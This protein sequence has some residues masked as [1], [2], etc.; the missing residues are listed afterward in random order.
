[1]KTYIINLPQSAERRAAME[2]QLARFPELKAEFVAAVDGR[3]MSE[4][5]VRAAFDAERARAYYGRSLTRGEVGCTL[6]HVRCY[7]RI[8]EGADEVALILEDDAD[9][10]TRLPD[11]APLEAMLSRTRRPTVVLLSGHYWYWPGFR[12]ELKRVFCAYYTHSY[13]INRPAARLLTERF[14]R[15]F[16]LADNW[17][18]VRRQGVRVLAV[19]PHWINQISTEATSTVLDNALRNSASRTFIRA[20]LSLRHLFRSYGNKV[21]EKALFAMNCYEED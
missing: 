15:P 18:H 16:H 7:N 5:E 6:S 14:S 21:I 12:R 13:L 2:G 11:F 10:G 3:A 20:N 19:C 9:L 8:A 1:M 4:E 17:I